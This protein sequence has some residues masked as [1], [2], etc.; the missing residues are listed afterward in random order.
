MK[1][2]LLFLMIM[3]LALT[4][5][6]NSQSADE[7]ILDITM[8]GGSPTGVWYMVTNGIS[9]CINTSF[10]GSI[11]MINPGGGVSNPQRIGSNE[12]QS[13]MT[14]SILALAATRGQDPFEEA[15]PN[16]A[17]IAG[18]YPSTFQIVLTEKLGVSSFDE[19][20]ENK[21]PVRLSIDKPASSA[22]VAFERMLKEY[23]VTIEE[24]EAWGAD[25]LLKNFADSSSMLSD[26][27]IDGFCIST[28]VPAP[29]VIES[30][31]SR[32]LVLID[33]NTDIINALV[34]TYGYSMKTIEADTYNFANEDVH[35]ISATSILAISTDVSDDVAYKIAQSINE[36]LDYMRNVH[37]AMSKITSESITQDLGVPLHPGAMQY[38]KDM[39]IIE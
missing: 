27:L 34:D 16:L 7:E 21:L 37:I 25:I 30:A 23:D 22:N 38:Y 1:K 19:I 9:E 12:A 18:F 20:I 5:C 6:Q 4:G 29:A 14:H 24:M 15:I 36:N 10:P 3:V 2:V 11:V 13:G 28:L 8:L 33:V 26:G 35:T 31:L 32:D 17:S 39:G